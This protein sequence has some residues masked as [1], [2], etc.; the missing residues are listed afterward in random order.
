MTA[1]STPHGV[2]NASRRAL[3]HAVR[4]HRTLL[5]ILALAALLRIAFFVGFG[6]GDDLGYIYYASEILG[7]HYPALAPLSQYAYRPLLLLLFAAGIGTFGYTDMGVVAPVLLAS[8]AATAFI[9]VFVRRVMDPRA[10]W[11]CALLYACEPFNV[12]NSTTMTNDVILSCLVLI[13]TGLFVIGERRSAGS[14]RR[15]FIASGVAMTAA[16]LVKMT[17]LPAVVVLGMY[18]AWRLMRS[19]RAAIRQHRWFFVTFAGGL[20][21]IC[22]GYFLATGD[23]LWQFRSEFSYYETFKPEWYLAGHIDYR[24]LMLEYPRSL[25]GRVGY[26]AFLFREHGVLFWLVIP[27]LG[28]IAWRRPHPVL[29]LLAVQAVVIFSFFEFYPQYLKPYYLPLVRQTRYLELLLPAAAIVVGVMLHRLSVR[30]RAAAVA[31]LCLVLGDFVYE[32]SRRATLYRDSQMDVREL[33]RYAASTIRSS[34]KILMADMPARNALSFYLRD[35][36]VNVELLQGDPPADSYIAI[37]GARSFWW[38]SEMISDIDPAQVPPNWVLA[39]AAEGRRAPWRRSNL[40]VYYVGEPREESFSL[41]DDPAAPRSDCPRAGLHEVAFGAGF[42]HPGV[43]RLVAAIPDID[44]LTRLSAPRLEW[45]GWLQADDAVYTIETSSDDGSW[46]YLNGRLVL[47]NGGTHPAMTARKTVRLARGWYA[48]RLRYE[49][50][51]A[52]QFL[53]FRVLDGS[54]LG[55]TA[56][57]TVSFCGEPPVGT[58]RGVVGGS[59]SI[60]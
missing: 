14:G 8:L 15:W 48:F 32:A 26:E 24:N 25:F 59:A 60:R 7:G 34:G 51:V 58:A 23:P 46:V 40:R 38:S 42:D 54:G 31:V 39:Y 17:I 41:F 47:D 1:P 2:I 5:A 49:N 33:A 12:V 53:R 13:S 19:P 21:C 55:S 20:V 11:W 43:D 22:F 37:G 16:F 10:G 3:V 57:P 6:L 27:A 4:T 50:S 36:G 56:A 9:Y 29:G 18:S 28:W 52:D 30:H 44:N 45:T 35:G